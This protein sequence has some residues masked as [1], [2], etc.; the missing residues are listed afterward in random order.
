MKLALKGQPKFTHLKEDKADGTPAVRRRPAGRGS[1]PQA[2]R[3]P[4]LWARATVSA[5]PLGHDSFCPG[6]PGQAW[7]FGRRPALG[8]IRQRFQR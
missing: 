3:L 6:N 5:A 2:S 7:P 4:C 1:V 8:Y